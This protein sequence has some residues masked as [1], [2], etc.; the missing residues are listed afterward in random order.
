VP[1]REATAAETVRVELQDGTRLEGYLRR[2]QPSL[3]LVQSGDRLYEIADYEI[4]SVDGRAGAPPPQPAAAPLVRSD[5]Y[6]V[7]RPNGDVEEWHHLDA[8]NETGKVW[9]FLRW[10]ATERELDQVKRMEVYDT[11]QHRLP[12]RVEP[13]AGSDVYDVTVDLAVPIA[14]GESMNVTQRYLFPGMARRQGDR[15]TLTF[16]GDFPE[17]RI[18]QRKVQLPP[19]ARVQS[20]DPA[21]AERFE[22]D[23]STIIVWR[24]YYPR[25]VRFPLTVVYQLPAEAGTR[26]GGS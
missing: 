7:V 3:Y 24:R 20:I 6:Q 13:R 9:T 19:G 23:G 2:I 1:S 10:G 25:G 26:G 17:D 21:P 18:H 15:F 5:V 16:A 4:A 11:Y 14:P 8:T 12:H 22:H